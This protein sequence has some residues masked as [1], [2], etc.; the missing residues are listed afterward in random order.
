MRAGLTKRGAPALLHRGDRFWGRQ[1]C[2]GTPVN[3]GRDRRRDEKV[4]ADAGADAQAGEPPTSPSVA[5]APPVEQAEAPLVSERL[6][7][8]V[9]TD[10]LRRLL[11]LMAGTELLAEMCRHLTSDGSA[12]EV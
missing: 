9:E 10:E 11:C 3:G 1:V 4:R 6:H 5:M 7:Y 2:R 12:G 8:F